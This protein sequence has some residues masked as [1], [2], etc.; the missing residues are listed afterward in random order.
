MLLN[1]A[2]TSDAFRN[3]LEVEKKKAVG[4]NA[5][6][7]SPLQDHLCAVNGA[8]GYKHMTDPSRGK[9]RMDPSRTRPTFF[10]MGA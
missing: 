5:W 3:Y 9:S 10:S 2:V 4:G 8:S 7:S 6:D 1:F